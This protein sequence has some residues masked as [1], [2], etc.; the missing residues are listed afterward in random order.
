MN[1]NW[2][3]KDSESLKNARGLVEGLLVDPVRGPDLAA[4]PG[5]EAGPDHAAAQGLEAGP[6]RTQGPNLG[7]NTE[8][9]QNQLTEM[10]P[11]KM[12]PK[13]GP[14]LGPTQDPDHVT[15]LIPNQN[16]D[17]DPVQEM[18]KIIGS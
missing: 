13:K 10:I 9:A 15:D 6:G 2:M 14:N 18:I 16:L 12:G 4:V 11:R 3:E 1:L 8:V 17:R 5:L 7:P